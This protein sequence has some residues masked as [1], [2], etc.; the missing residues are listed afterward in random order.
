[1]R[2]IKPI[3]SYPADGSRANQEL[4]DFKETTFGL[5]AG[6]TRIGGRKENQDSSGYKE[7]K[8]GLLIVV[9]DGMGGAKGGKT[10]S[11]L[12]IDVIINEVDSSNL[13]DNADILVDAIGK[14]NEQVYNTS[15]AYTELTGMG[16]TVVALLIDENKATAAHV[17]DSR[18]YQVRGGRKV[19][20]TFDHSMVFEL[21]R[22]GT[23]TEEQARLSA[24]SNVILR[25]IGTKPA[26]EIEV[27]NDLPYLKGD[28]FLLC[29]DGICGATSEKDLLKLIDT[30]KNIKE[31][32]EALVNTIDQIGINSGGKHD[33][34]TAAFIQLNLNSKIKPKMDKKSKII[35]GIVLFL[36]ILSISVNCIQYFSSGKIQNNTLPKEN[37]TPAANQ[38]G[39]VEQPLTPAG[40]VP[41]SKETTSTPIKK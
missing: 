4:P 7:T 11:Q 5:L 21:V 35:I 30:H 15:R 29:S 3:E 26:M 32:T 18:I 8:H 22:R 40:T 27:D 17:G 12:A 10:A 20:R 38:Q 37:V 1:M 2:T 23:I 25:A 31:T 28:R 19:F 6:A 33:N 14:A 34:L 13:D 9:C 41:E 16:T 39:T 24:E 36:L